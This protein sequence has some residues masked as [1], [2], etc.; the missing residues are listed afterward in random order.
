MKPPQRSYADGR[1]GTL[2]NRELSGMSTEDLKRLRDALKR[3]QKAKPKPAPLHPNATTG[4]VLRVMNQADAILTELRT[5][6]WQWEANL[7]AVGAEQMARGDLR[8][9]AIGE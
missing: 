1:H 4:D 2:M 8:P 7:D 6:L 9:R 5:I 3:R